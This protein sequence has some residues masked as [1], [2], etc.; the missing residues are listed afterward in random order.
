MLFDVIVVLIFTKLEKQS[1][2]KKFVWV[3]K[4]LWRCREHGLSVLH[5]ELEE[6]F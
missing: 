2:V 3:K 6:R 4:W 1:R 5:Q